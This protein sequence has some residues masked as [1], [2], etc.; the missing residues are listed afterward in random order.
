MRPRRKRRQ[1]FDLRTERE[2][3]GLRSE[4][5]RKLRKI[6]G[7]GKYLVRGGKEKQG[8]KMGKYWEKENSQWSKRI[9]GKEKEENIWGKK[10]LVLQKR[11]NR[12]RKYLV[13]RRK[14]EQERIRRKTKLRWLVLKD[15][16]T[17]VQTAF[18]LVDFTNSIE[19]IG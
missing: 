2:I 12:G 9:T 19:G 16:H 3:C 15:R 14:E 1:T 8:K 18:F 11:E 6:I 13:K 7:K 4:G 17:G 10:I 5:R